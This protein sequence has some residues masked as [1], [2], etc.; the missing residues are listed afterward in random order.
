VYWFTGNRW[1]WD[2][3][4]NNEWVAGHFAEDYAYKMGGGFFVDNAARIAIGFGGYRIGGYSEG[5]FEQVKV[6][7]W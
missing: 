4:I 6:S 5:H 7:A 2:Y 3:H 1:R